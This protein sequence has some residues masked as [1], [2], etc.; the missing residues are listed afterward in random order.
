MKRIDFK[1]DNN[2]KHLVFARHCLKCNT[3]SNFSQQAYKTGTFIIIPI[4]QIGKL[5]HRVVMKLAQPH[6]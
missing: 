3:Y 5:G 1:D 2:S 6:E 4:L